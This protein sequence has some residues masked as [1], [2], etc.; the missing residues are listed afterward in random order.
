LSQRC[1][2]WLSKCRFGSLTLAG[3]DATRIEAKNVSFTFGADLSRDLLVSLK[4]I[5]SNV[6]GQ[7]PLLAQ[8]IDI[9]IDSLI[10]E[11][12]LPTTVCRR[13]KQQFQLK[14]D[15]VT[16]LYL[17][18]ERTHNALL[19]TNPSFTLKIAQPGGSG[20]AEVDIVLPYAAFDL[21]VS[22]PIVNGTSRYF[23]PKRATNER[24]YILGRIFLQEAYVIADYERSNFSVL[25]AKFPPTD[26]PQQIV[27]IETPKKMD[28]SPH[29]GGAGLS[30]MAQGTQPR[31]NSGYRCWRSGRCYHSRSRT[32]LSQET[33]KTAPSES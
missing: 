13:F 28:N 30:K 19:A 3:Y 5:T 26:V 20:N 31:R 23:P 2:C 15:N 10:T 25:Q 17:L 4:S 29:H 8:S 11:L 1:A 7:P 24:Q 12:W 27:S 9:F 33:P 14:N 6:L 18:D 21:S 32:A 16:E 22:K